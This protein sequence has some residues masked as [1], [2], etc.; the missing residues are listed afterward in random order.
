MSYEVELKVKI[1]NYADMLE[2]LNQRGCIWEK[3]VRQSDRI[4]Y[5]PSRQN[6]SGERDLFFRI[7]SENGRHILT[8]KQILDSTEVVEYESLIGNEK[9]VE[10]ML[11]LL[12]FEDYVTVAKTRKTGAVGD[13]TI[14]MD[15]V[16]QLGCFMEV[17][18]VVASD[19]EREKARKELNGFLEELGTG[20]GQVCDKRYHTMMRELDAER[21]REI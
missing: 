4:Y 8:L 16:D 3:T 9:E 19:G 1:E 12:Q 11:Y 7:R 20:K 6:T 18:K 10:K 13:I 21:K 17:E 5:Q 14:C 15:E 2:V